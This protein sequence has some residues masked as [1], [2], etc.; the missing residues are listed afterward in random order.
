MKPTADNRIDTL[1]RTK[2]QNILSVYFT[3]GYPRVEDTVEIIQTLEKTGADMVEIGI[4]FSDPTADGPVIQHSNEVALKNGMSLNILFSQ[5]ET[6]RGKVSVPL[7]LMG[8]VNP[9]YQYGFEKF[10]RK[11]RE[12]GIDGVILPDLP[13]DEFKANYRSFF[14]ENQLH[15]ILLVTP[16]TSDD[17]IREIDRLST[18]FIYLV[19]SA[20]TTGSANKGLLSQAAYFN[21]IRDMKLTNPYLS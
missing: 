13:P 10:C 11:C 17:R 3:A 20:S 15:N 16:Q 5:L 19:S 2:K 9:V 12:T 6:I 7:L 4:P 14:E 18:G 1:F 21:K 8:Y